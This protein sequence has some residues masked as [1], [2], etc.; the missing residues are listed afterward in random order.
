MSAS[1]ISIQGAILL[2]VVACL[3][4]FQAQAWAIGFA[5]VS[6]AAAAVLYTLRV[7]ALLALEHEERQRAQMPEWARA[8]STKPA[9]TS[10]AL[11]RARPGPLLIVAAIC[12]VALVPAPLH[13]SSRD[14][15]IAAAL[16]TAFSA[17]FVSTLVDWFYIAPMLRQGHNEELMLCR[18][19]LGR[20]W[21]SVTRV[22][23]FHRLGAMLGFVLGLVAV[24][25][26]LASSLIGLDH[27]LDQVAAGA[28]AALTTV[29]AGFYL[30]RARDVIA[31]ALRPA[32][33]V[34]DKI[35]LAG[36]DEKERD[37]AY[38]V[39]DVALEGVRLLE[40]QGKDDTV[41]DQM[42]AWRQHDRILDFSEAAKLVRCR[43]RFE[44]CRRLE[45]KRV[46]AY[47]P[48]NQTA[49]SVDGAGS[50]SQ[51]EEPRT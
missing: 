40:V 13:E 35:K 5:G 31:F 7:R 33:H 8:A 25:T 19:S 26:L 42:Q 32:F 36:D 4:I 44:P 21:R 18:S 46:N 48:H 15:E 16:T 12:A 27:G 1:G 11:K 10:S 39:V 45:C 50:H 38:F 29:L 22:W 47:C 14:V 6:V 24:V 9:A 30:A 23:L 49:P 43:R 34:G 3:N 17:T 2:I 51:P 41:P 37:R 20:Q 28:I